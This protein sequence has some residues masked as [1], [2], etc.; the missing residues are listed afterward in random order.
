[1]QASARRPRRCDRPTRR[2]A[3]QRRQRRAAPLLGS[4]D[5]APRRRRRKVPHADDAFVV[6]RHERVAVRRGD[7]S[8][9]PLASADAH[10]SPPSAPRR[11]S[12][13]SSP[14]AANR[15]PSAAKARAATAIGPAH[16]GRGRPEGHLR[17]W[18]KT[19]PSQL[20]D[21]ARRP[22]ASRQALLTSVSCRRRAAAPPAGR[23]PLPQAHARVP[24]PAQKRAPAP[25]PEPSPPQ[26]PRP[27]THETASSCASSTLRVRP[28][29]SEYTHG[30]VPRADDR[31]VGPR[32]RR[33]ARQRELREAHDVAV[34][35]AALCVGGEPAG[36]VDP[37]SADATRRAE[38]SVLRRGERD[39][40]QGVTQ[41]A[42][43][44]LVRRKGSGRAAQA[45]G[46]EP[47][48]R[49][50]RR[51]PQK[52]RIETRGRAA[53][54]R[55][56]GSGGRGGAGAPRATDVALRASEDASLGAAR[57]TDVASVARG[58]SPRA[59]RAGW[60]PRGRRVR[61]R[62]AGGG[63]SRPLAAAERVGGERVGA[64]GLAPN[65]LAPNGLAPLEWAPNGRAPL[66]R[67]PFG[68]VPWVGTLGRR[69]GFAPNARPRAPDGIAP[70]SPERAP[71]PSL[72]APP[73]RGGR[74]R[75]RPA[76][77]VGRPRSRASHRRSGT[78]AARR[79]AVWAS[80]QILGSAPDAP[81]L[82]GPK[83]PPRPPHPRR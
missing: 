8:A 49:R 78:G 74:L 44:A 41:H 57:P 7:V 47:R 15:L 32:R 5:A 10:C 71:R 42:V 35:R 30:A 13:P 6:A 3:R 66:E 83:W 54:P 58:C 17:S 34:R 24:R 48:G 67:A 46:R 60:L 51:P 62:P 53:R 55:P 28:S 73:R 11:G 33:D 40:A 4:R 20:P 76:R 37:S 12:R 19:C 63:G 29:D 69:L 80:A 14:S 52:R 22:V 65:G 81:P 23:R 68:S 43:T 18:T 50:R 70:R 45:V 75:T 82:H 21:A 16:S 59:R 26:G 61:R 72:R 36:R 25:A 39:V 77:R 27:A 2:H 9:P 79:T 31:A 38:R 1:M 56:A 64:N